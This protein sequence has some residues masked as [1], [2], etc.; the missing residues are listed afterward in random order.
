MA[1]QETYFVGGFT[2]VLLHLLF[3]ENMEVE[4]KVSYEVLPLEATMED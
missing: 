1:V 3:P 2:A 4:E